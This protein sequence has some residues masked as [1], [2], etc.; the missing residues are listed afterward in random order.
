MADEAKRGG[1]GGK[2]GRAGRVSAG[3]SNQISLMKW[4]YG[5]QPDE[6]EATASMPMLPEPAILGGLTLVLGHFISEIPDCAQ[7][8]KPAP[9]AP[10]SLRLHPAWLRPPWRLEKLI[11]LNQPSF[12]LKKGQA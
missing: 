2:E 6:P 7:W 9:P 10:L 5:M 11:S 4:I 12:P 1:G 3:A 8:Q